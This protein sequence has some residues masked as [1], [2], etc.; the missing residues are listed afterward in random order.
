MPNI[1]QRL[2]RFRPTETLGTG[3]TSISYGYVDVKEK[4]P[5]LSSGQ[6]WKNYSDIMVNV[7]IVG[8]GV[9]YFLNLLAKVT[10]KAVPVD[11]TPEAKEYADRVDTVMGKLETPWSKVIRRAALYRFYGFGLQEWVATKLPDGT[12]GFSRIEPR[13]VHTIE[14]WDI[15]EDTTKIWGV[16]QRS[17]TT[18][19]E[20]YLPRAKLIYLVDDMVSDSPEGVGLFRHMFPLAKRLQ[21]LERVEA[22]GFETD[23][24]GI[25]IVRAPLALMDALV[26]DGTLTSDQRQVA[27]T[28]MDEFIT[29][30]IRSQQSGMR[31]DSSVY[32]SQDDAASPSSVRQWDVELLRGESKAFDG[33]DAA[34]ERQ[35]FG[36]ARLIGVEHLL[37]GSTAVGSFAL[38]KDKTQNFFL[39]VDS[40]LNEIAECFNID[41]LGPLWKLNGW[42][43]EMK[44]RLQPEPIRFRD[45]EQIAGTLASMA[46]A[47]AVLDP[48][49]PA[50][51]EL[52]DLMGLSRVDHD[53]MAIDASLTT[54]PPKDENKTVPADEIG[55]EENADPGSGN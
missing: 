16:I 18:S 31:L 34:I 25:P 50:I 54:P 24:R 17:P 2:T 21:R 9:R 19:K 53:E 3:G 51:N 41:F 45:V 30:H 22:D 6:R 26:K 27:L 38:S 28:K 12:I 37:L 15:D 48:D 42:P 10:W 36:I 49:D 4:E 35:I 44:P 32:R 52:R 29:N 7:G 5:E 8:A 46:Q 33:I 13:P 1:F 47:G 14:R 43:D 40:S 20:I 23:L 55:G 11:D 39:V